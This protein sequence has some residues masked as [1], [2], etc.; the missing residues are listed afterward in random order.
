MI[1]ELINITERRNQYA[2]I[3]LCVFYYQ[4]VMMENTGPYDLNIP[5]DC[6]AT[7]T[8]TILV[9]RALALGY[10]TVAL[11]VQVGLAVG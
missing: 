4:I 2:Y 1:T 10:R 8:P 11:N 5:V 6:A 7:T 9:K 3:K